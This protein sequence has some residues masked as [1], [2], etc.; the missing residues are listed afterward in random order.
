MPTGS[1]ASQRAAG[2]TEPVS[3]GWCHELSYRSPRSIRSAIEI[4]VIC[5]ANICRSPMAE[6][7]LGVR[8][9]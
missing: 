5:T 4:L 6:A 1:D 7:L 9:A 3:V 2:I 8:I